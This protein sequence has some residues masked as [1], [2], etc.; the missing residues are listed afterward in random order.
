MSGISV[1]IPE[2]PAPIKRK[3][4][5]ISSNESWS[6]ID[7]KYK[8][9]KQSKCRYNNNNNNQLLVNFKYNQT[10]PETPLNDDNKLFIN[11][12]WIFF[13]FFQFVFFIKLFFG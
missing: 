5:S 8:Y 11:T 7:R 10:I 13:N 4:C 12:F 6:S 2:T 3:S 9:K 1:F